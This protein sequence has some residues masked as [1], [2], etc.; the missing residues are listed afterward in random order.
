TG[1]SCISPKQCT[2]PCRAKGCKHG[3]CMNRKCHCM[4]CL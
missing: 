1:T 4:L 3:K 2:E